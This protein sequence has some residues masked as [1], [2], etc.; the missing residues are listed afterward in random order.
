[1]LKKLATLPVSPQV[2]V[3]IALLA[4]SIEPIIAKFA[5]KY[6][7]SAYQLILL[8]NLLGALFLLP[9]ILKTQRPSKELLKECFFISLLLFSTNTLSLLSLE[10]IS[11][12]YL[13]T[14]VTCVPALVALFNLVLQRETLSRLFWPGFTLC[15]SGVLLTLDLTASQSN[16]AILGL[17]F[18][19][20]AALSSSIYRVKMEI[21]CEK[22]NPVQAAALSYF[23][24][25]PLSL[26]LLFF[27]SPI[28]QSS[29]L[30]GAWI[31]IAAAL[32]NLAFIYALSLV[33]STRISLLTMLQRPMLVIFAAITLKETISTMQAIGI[34]LVFFGIN[35]A[36]VSRNRAGAGSAQPAPENARLGT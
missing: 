11:V 6:G 14:I 30:F 27:A 25:G 35:M 13:I 4:A 34:V 18:A 24:Q 33:G 15:F 17:I 32:A 7:A 19:F 31:A 22:Q 16:T 9:V 5:Y 26:P 28:A 29:L 1:M 8:K 36:Q 20:A 21:I 23:L 10:S 3:L 2:W 12:V